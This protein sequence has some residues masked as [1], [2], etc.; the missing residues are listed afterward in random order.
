M[1]ASKGVVL[2][3]ANSTNAATTPVYWPG[4]FACLM[5]SA[6]VFPT[7][8]FLQ[9]QNNDGTWINM[10][11]ATVTSSPTTISANSG[12]GYNLPAGQ[13]R[14]NLTGGTCTALTAVLSSVAFD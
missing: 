10:A 1:A 8:C 7:T 4:G 12:Y 14:M 2:C 9:V 6:T 5:I 13:V 3:S 11:P